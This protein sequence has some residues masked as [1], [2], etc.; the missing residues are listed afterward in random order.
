MGIVTLIPEALARSRP[1]ESL[2][3]GKLVF[4]ILKGEKI[5]IF[6]YTCSSVVNSL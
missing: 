4:F 2:R 5:E 1:T 3:F 6:H